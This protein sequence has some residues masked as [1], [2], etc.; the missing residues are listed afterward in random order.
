MSVSSDLQQSGIEGGEDGV[1]EVVVT[2]DNVDGQVHSHNRLLLSALSYNVAVGKTATQSSTWSS[3]FVNEGG[4]A[5]N[6]VDG[7][8]NGTFDGG[9][10]SHTSGWQENDS[11]GLIWWKVDLGQSFII[12]M[13][14]VY[15]RIDCCKSRLAGFELTILRAGTVVWIHKDLSTGDPPDISTL[16]VPYIMGDEVKITQTTTEVLNLAE[17]EVYGEDLYNVAFGNN[18]TQSYTGTWEGINGW[19]HHAVD[20]NTEDRLYS[21]GSVTL[22]P[23]LNSSLDEVSWWKVELVRSFTIV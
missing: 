14:K 22:A 11:L 12:D 17:V 8:T 16:D 13:I 6:A 5:S 10:V 9:S 4:A 2:K 20:G 15:N 18:A 21:Q 3:E 1:H 19:A 7:N 23:N